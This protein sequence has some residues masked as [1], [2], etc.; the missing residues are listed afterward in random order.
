MLILLLIFVSILG[1]IFKKEI[2]NEN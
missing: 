1:I 2:K